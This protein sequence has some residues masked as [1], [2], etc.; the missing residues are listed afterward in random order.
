MS[1]LNLIASLLRTS[2]I[3]TNSIPSLTCT[4]LHNILPHI[5]YPNPS[6]IMRMPSSSSFILVATLAASSS[7]PSLA[8]PAGEPSEGG[9]TTS[10]SNHLIASRNGPIPRAADQDE[11]A[12]AH[13]QQARGEDLVN[14]PHLCQALGLVRNVPILGVAVG[15]V[16]DLLCPGP[17]AA[18]MQGMNAESNE[19]DAEAT[20]KLATAVG[21]VSD[22]LAGAG[23][24]PVVGDTVPIG[25]PIAVVSGAPVPLKDASPL[26]R[27]GSAADPASSSTPIQTTDS[28]YPAATSTDSAK[29][30]NNTPNIAAAATLPSP[31]TGAA[32]DIDIP[33]VPGIVLPILTP[34]VAGGPPV[35]AQAPLN[36]AAVEMDAPVPGGAAP[37]APPTAGGPV[38]PA[39]ADAAPP[40]PP[41][42][43]NPPAPA[44]DAPAPPSG[45]PQPPTGST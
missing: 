41:N 10:S 18:S 13:H 27:D 30:P 35:P 9:M 5:H 8:A 19:H 4:L 39:P 25:A 17:G 34:I 36:I 37:P 28:L 31:V 38:P 29:T 44:N 42:G 40:A 26:R 43:P 23:R 16:L 11:V 3:Y 32:G 2:T 21:V 1:A 24:V 22:I 33:L 6:S 12:D 15:P 7:T 20:E 45:A 14:P